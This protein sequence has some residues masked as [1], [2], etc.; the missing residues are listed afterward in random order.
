MAKKQKKLQGKTLHQIK[1]IRPGKDEAWLYKRKGE[2]LLVLEPWFATRLWFNEACQLIDVLRAAVPDV[3]FKLDDVVTRPPLIKNNARRQ[4]GWQQ[5]LERPKQDYIPLSM[6]LK[7]LAPLSE[8]KLN[9]NAE[10]FKVNE[11]FDCRNCGICRV[12]LGL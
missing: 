2:F 7:P 3:K 9:F 10:Q 11:P 4:R 1:V 5:E 12:C 8:D 6:L